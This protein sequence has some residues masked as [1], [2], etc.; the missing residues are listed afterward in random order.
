MNV[1]AVDPGR[2]TGLAT[3]IEGGH[4]AWAESFDHAQRTVHGYVSGYGGDHIDLVV[5]EDFII[6]ANTLKK[7]RAG[8]KE[9]IEFIGVG[10][11]LSRCYG[12]EFITQPPSDAF[13]FSTREKLRALG[14]KT[15]GPGDHSRS[16][17]QHLLLALVNRR[18]IDLAALATALG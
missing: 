2:T 3:W 12:I 17:S 18:L 8:S 14:W 6:S 7:S 5:F 13:S 9:A 4:C 11:Y 1:L 15:P 16:A 10:R